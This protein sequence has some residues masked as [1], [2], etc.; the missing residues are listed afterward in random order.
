MTKMLNLP[1]VIVEDS[2]ETESTIILSVKVTKKTAVCPR[3]GQTSHRLHQ[4]KRHLVKDLPISNR[5]VI[6]DVNRRQFKCEFCRKP[7]SEILDFVEYKKS[8][9]RRLAQNITEQVIHSDINNVAK[10]NKLTSEQVES[11][12]TVVAE[13]VINVDV[14]ELRRLGIDEISLVKGQGKFIVV[15]VDLETHKLLGLVPERKQS[16]IEKVMLKWGEEVLNQ[17]EEVSMDMS[18]SYKSLVKRICPNA[19]VT[20][21]RFHVTKI[22]HEELNKARIDQKK[23]A[24]SLEIKE[25]AKLFDGL[26]GSKY[27]LLKAESNLS[28]EQKAKL[29]HVKS[30]SPLVKIMHSLKEEFHALFE[31]CKNLGSGI[32]ELIDW[33]KKAQPYYKKSVNTIKRWFAEVVGYFEQR[34]NNGMVEGINNKLKLLKRSGFGFRNFKNFEMRALL[35][36]HFPKDLAY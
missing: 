36:W 4:N 22:I 33:L 18:G 3:C 30:A 6:L 7:F 12:V 14:R 31:N 17:I 2:L 19:V 10:N 1:G 28:Q 35:F 25:R 13:S 32:L 5:A 27:I 26:K 20:V 23:A 11:M 9:T 34:T 16:C 8:F 24:E 29:L 21:D 15:L